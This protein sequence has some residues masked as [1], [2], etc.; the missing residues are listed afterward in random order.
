VAGVAQ[1]RESALERQGD[2]QGEQGLRVLVVAVVREF[3]P[4]RVRE[5]VEALGGRQ[6]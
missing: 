6:D 3:Q 1:I 2:V 5:G 4:V